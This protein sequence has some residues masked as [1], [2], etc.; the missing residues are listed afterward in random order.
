M[1]L[2]LVPLV[3]CC[4]TVGSAP[5]QQQAACPANDKARQLG[6]YVR[7]CTRAWHSPVAASNPRST[8]PIGHKSGHIQDPHA[9]QRLEH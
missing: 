6:L 1:H 4:S 8:P 9:A 7:G 3:P 2:I 5:V